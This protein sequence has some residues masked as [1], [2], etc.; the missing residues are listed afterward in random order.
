MKYIAHE[1]LG[2]DEASFC[3]D[4]AEK[5]IDYCRDK[6]IDLSNPAAAEY[7]IQEFDRKVTKFNEWCAND[8]DKYI[9][10]IIAAISKT[11][12]RG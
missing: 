3:S 2:W 10:D 7:A 4:Y 6:G 9:G 12:K 5:V 1:K 8:L 11:V